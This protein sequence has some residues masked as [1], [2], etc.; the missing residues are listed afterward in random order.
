MLVSRWRGGALTEQAH[1]EGGVCSISAKTLIA[2]EP[3]SGSVELGY[4]SWSVAF[5]LSGFYKREYLSGFAPKTIKLCAS[6]V[7]LHLVLE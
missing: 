4:N 1:Q 6:C 3:T 7:G 5:G 2:S